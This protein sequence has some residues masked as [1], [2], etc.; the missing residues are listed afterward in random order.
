MDYN[1]ELPS[2]LPLIQKLI[3]VFWILYNSRPTNP[4]Y[5]TIHVPGNYN[6]LLILQWKIFLVNYY[7]FKNIGLKHTEAVVYALIEILHSLFF[8]EYLNFFPSHI[9]TISKYYLDFLLCEDVSV[10]Y[11]AK[12]AL[13]RALKPHTLG[14]NKQNLVHGENSYKESTEGNKKK[15]YSY[16]IYYIGIAFLFI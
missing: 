15:V 3:S 2:S 5:C 1:V 7:L 14:K 4:F 8:Y 16:L 9:N 10:S 6:I 12:L 13:T 11:T